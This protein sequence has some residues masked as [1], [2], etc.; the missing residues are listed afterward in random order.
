M[1][2]TLNIKD[3]QETINA[4]ATT[5]AVSALESGQVLYLPDLSFPILTAEKKFLS[6]TYSDLKNKNISFDCRNNSLQGLNCDSSEYQQFKT[7][8]Q[9]Y[10]SRTKTLLHNLLPLYSKHLMQAR[11]SYRP[12]EIAGRKASSYRKDDTRLHVDA[13]PSNPTQG[14]RILRVF[15]NINPNAKPRVWRLGAPFGEVATTFLPAISKPLPSSA[16]LLATFKLTKSR[17]T[18]YDHYM[19]QLH[20]RMKADL[21]YQ[22]SVS[23]QEMLFPAHSTWIVFT[24]QVSHAAMTGQYVFEQ[25][26][27]LPPDKL[28]EPE[29]SPLKILERMLGAA[30]I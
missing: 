29:K 5:A 21:K 20:N 7:M 27:Y 16:F 24:D 10:A 28:T 4:A 14:K 22:Q 17:R 6:E 25:T 15:T 18:L 8:M 11:T 12:V 9:R 2:T 26:F 3:W 30:L 19:L 1:I 13:F 23:Q